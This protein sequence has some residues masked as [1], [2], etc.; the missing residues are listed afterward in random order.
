[1]PHRLA[2]TYAKLHNG[3]PSPPEPSPLTSE[4]SGYLNALEDND[5]DV[6]MSSEEEEEEPLPP[7]GPLQASLLGPFETAHRESSTRAVCAITLDQTNVAITS[8][9]VEISVEF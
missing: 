9:V 4:S 5:T 8:R 3:V 7:C 2:I 6:S 1:M